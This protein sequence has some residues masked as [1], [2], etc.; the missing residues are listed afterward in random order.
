MSYCIIANL[1]RYRLSGVPTGILR[2]IRELVSRQ[3]S[4]TLVL[5]KDSTL[6]QFSVA[7][8]QYALPNGEIHVE[9]LPDWLFMEDSRE[10]LIH[11]LEALISARNIQQI[12]AVGV[13]DTGYVAA[14]ASHLRKIRM[15]SLLLYRDVFSMHRNQPH[16]LETV[17]RR[18][19]TL[20][21]MNW[22]LL[23]HLSCF[24]DL[25]GKAFAVDLFPE[26]VAANWCL[27][28]DEPAHAGLT[29][30]EP[31]V[32]TTGTSSNLADIADLID[33]ITIAMQR[34]NATRWIH[35]GDI[36]T[37]LLV[38]LSK[39]LALTGL[40][41]T[42]DCLPP[43]SPAR[44]GE[45]VK[46]A[47]CVVIPRGELDTGLGIRELLH[48]DVPIDLPFHRQSFMVD[49]RSAEARLHYDR[50]DCWEGALEKMLS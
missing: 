11:R 35:A 28:E 24:Q 13:Y 7:H 41:D 49:D 16:E 5:P 17:C 37:Q 9:W 48:W 23:D 36:D 46:R 50:S 21:T 6:G 10:Q 40:L 15:S 12:C 43:M 8:E 30:E 32:A 19:H 29:L 34:E 14:I 39:S 33:R 47:K 2:L 3:V 27:F 26:D 18:A 42:F 38:R 44:Y 45:F 4:V 25:D 22:Q 1:R 31:Y 20:L